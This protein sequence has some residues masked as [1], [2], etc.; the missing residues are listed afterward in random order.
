[1]PDEPARKVALGELSVEDAV[2]AMPVLEIDDPALREENERLKERISELE[3]TIRNLTEAT[4]GTET[5]LKG[6]IKEI[7]DTYEARLQ[8]A[9]KRIEEL[10]GTCNEQES[11]IKVLD[12]RAKGLEKELEVYSGIR[13]AFKVIIAEEA[14]YQ[15]QKALASMPVRSNALKIEAEELKVSIEHSEVTQELSTKTGLGKIMYC[16]LKDLE[17]KPSSEA[18]ISDALQEHGW[19]MAHSTLAPNLA[20]LVKQGLLVRV[21]GKPLRYRPPGKVGLEVKE[22]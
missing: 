9:S 15:V 18:E 2:K 1:L 13:E 8:D 7:T 5:R 16:I 19:P 14:K 12:E 11:T 22:A 21:E 4:A 6:E 3:G 10:E 20:Q 17:G